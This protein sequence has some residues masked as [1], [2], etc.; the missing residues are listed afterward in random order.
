MLKIFAAAA[1]GYVIG[2]LVNKALMDDLRAKHKWT[3]A[4]LLRQAKASSLKSDR[5]RQQSHQISELKERLE[6]YEEDGQ[7]VLE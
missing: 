5:I 7:N 3:C 4:Q 1:F 2:T 6:K